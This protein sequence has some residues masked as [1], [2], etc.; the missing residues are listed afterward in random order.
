MKTQFLSSGPIC[1]RTL[2]LWISAEI[3]LIFPP[4]QSQ[5]SFALFSPGGKKLKDWRMKTLYFVVRSSALKSCRGWGSVWSID[6][7]GFN[8]L[9]YDLL[10]DTKICFVY[11]IPISYKLTKYCYVYSDVYHSQGF[12][13]QDWTHSENLPNPIIVIERISF[14]NSNMMQG[15]I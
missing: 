15:W 10:I 8:W 1:C 4:H 13:S 11:L 5:P 3:S 2:E 14:T 9:W 12:F 7:A 6:K